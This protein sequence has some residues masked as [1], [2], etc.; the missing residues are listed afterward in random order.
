MESLVAAIDRM[1]KIGLILAIC[2]L[3]VLSVRSTVLMSEKL[4][5]AERRI[6]ELELKLATASEQHN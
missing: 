3:A 1:I 4:R 5:E 2:G 6:F